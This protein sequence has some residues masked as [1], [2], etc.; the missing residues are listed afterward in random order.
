MGRFTVEQ[1]CVETRL[2]AWLTCAG[3]AATLI[4]CHPPRE[5]ELTRPPPLP[6]CALGDV[7]VALEESD[8]EHARGALDALAGTSTCA[9]TPELASLRWEVDVGSAAL[10]EPSLRAAAQWIERARTGPPAERAGALR[11]ARAL[12]RRF[13]REQPTRVVRSLDPAVSL[14]ETAFLIGGRLA[15]TA[16]TLGVFAFTTAGVRLYSLDSATVPELGATSVVV[17]L[18][19]GEVRTLAEDATRRRWTL[20]SQ[21]DGVVLVDAPAAHWVV[22]DVAGLLAVHRVASVKG[23]LVASLDVVDLV[24][25]A[26]RGHWDRAPIGVSA[27]P[28]IVFDR[29]GKR[30]AIAVEGRVSV[31]SL[32]SGRFEDVTLPETHPPSGV[33]LAFTEDGT[34]LC[35]EH[36]GVASL[37]SAGRQRPIPR[38]AFHE[39]TAHHRDA[40]PLS[41]IADGS[42]SAAT[43][44]APLGMLTHE[45]G[46]VAISRSRQLAAWF[47]VEAGATKRHRVRVFDATSGKTVRTA[48]VDEPPVDVG[49]RFS[50]DDSVV[51][52]SYPSGVTG[53]LEVATGKDVP[54][55]E[56][57]PAC[58]ASSATLTCVVREPRGFCAFGDLFAPQ[59]VCPATSR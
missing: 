36:L 12:L 56:L 34:T 4:G 6:A 14:G 40:V 8:Y 39:A 48:Q 31:A 5:P 15:P 55:P 33:R 10:R 49:L 26:P 1:P 44:V 24:S 53:A 52:W 58:S 17:Q 19:S 18:G 32:P 23:E 51:G 9:A 45:L 13:T 46:G 50:S 16:T 28:Q 20:T 59:E 22:D 54:F 30:L 35:F 42:W 21:P 7:S 27:P 41:P 47:E 2:R 11:I 57:S 25:G 3:C 37:L 43:G 29:A 38:C